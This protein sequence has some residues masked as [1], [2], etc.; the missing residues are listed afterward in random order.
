[1][2]EIQQCYW[3][4]PLLKQNIPENVLELLRPVVK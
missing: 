1:M 3:L 2:S 4:T